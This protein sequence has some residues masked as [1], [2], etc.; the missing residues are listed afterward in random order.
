MCDHRRVTRG[1][2]QWKATVDHPAA[3][4]FVSLRSSVSDRDGNNQQQT[5]IRAYALK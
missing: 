5:V 3:A 1:H 2:D 4:A